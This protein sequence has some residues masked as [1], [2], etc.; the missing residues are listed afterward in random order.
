MQR[1]LVSNIERKWDVLVSNIERK[2]ES[3]SNMELKL[4]VSNIERK[5][6]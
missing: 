1:L 4:F 3:V 5:C 6:E 2:S